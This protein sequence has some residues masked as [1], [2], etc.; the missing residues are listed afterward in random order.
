ML[1]FLFLR[2]DD[3]LFMVVE[4]LYDIVKDTAEIHAQLISQ[5]AGQNFALVGRVV[6]ESRT[7]D[8]RNMVRIECR[9]YFRGRR[10]S[11]SHRFFLTRLVSGLTPS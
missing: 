1:V 2:V 10:M 11:V 4:T 6:P 8:R 9:M 5:G 7:P 3:L